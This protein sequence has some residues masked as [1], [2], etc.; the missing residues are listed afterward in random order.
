[1]AYRIIYLPTADIVRFGK[2]G[3]RKVFFMTKE[4]AI[5][6]LNNHDCLLRDGPND[7]PFYLKPS[8][9]SVC[10]LTSQ[11]VPKYLLEVIEIGGKCGE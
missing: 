6:W 4:L 10:Y 9:I 3:K 11:I 1:M 2:S 5:D 7:T 8:G